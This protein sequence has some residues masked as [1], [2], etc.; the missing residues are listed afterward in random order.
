[1]PVA[2]KDDPTSQASL[3]LSV[4]AAPFRRKPKTPNRFG[5]CARRIAVIVGKT[6][7]CELGQLPLTSAAAFG[8]TRNPRPPIARLRFL[9]WFGGRHR[10]RIGA[11]RTG[12]RRRG[13]HPHPPAAI[14]GGYP[15]PYTWP[16]NVLDWPSVNVPPASPTPAPRRRTTDGAADTESLLISVAAQLDS[17]LHWERHHPAPC[18]TAA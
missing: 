4:A 7:T 6:N 15:R 13:L 3:P 9:R 2:V 1:M 11:R 17:E 10:G 12:F 14:H 5:G 8:H 16:W 18:W